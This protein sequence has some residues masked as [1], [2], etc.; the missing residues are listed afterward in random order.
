MFALVK[1]KK[2]MVPAL[3]QEIEY[4]EVGETRPERGLE[5][6][7]KIVECSVSLCQEVLVGHC[8]LENLFEMG[9]LDC[10]YV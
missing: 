6:Q 3:C 4:F 9:W 5:K 8:M 1:K 10:Q 7:V 2:G